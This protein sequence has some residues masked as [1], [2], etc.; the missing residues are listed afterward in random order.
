[1]EETRG[2]DDDLNMFLD[3]AS[4]EEIKECFRRFRAV[5]S[6]DRLRIHRC[7]VCARELGAEEGNMSN[8]LDD[9]SI[10]NLLRPCHIHSAQVLWHGALVLG[11][12]I[13]EIDNAQSAWICND[14]EL[15]L[16][17]GK[18]PRFSLANNLWIGNIPYQLAALTIPE[19]LLI[20]RYYPRCYVFK[21]YPRGG[22]HLSPEV[23]QRGMKGNV[24]LYELNTKDVVRMLEGQ[25]MPNPAA[26][27][28][29]VLAITF[30]GSTA[31]PKDWLKS[32]FRVRRRRVY[33]ALL[34]LKENNSLYGDIC[35]QEDR[36]QSLPEDGVPEE[37]ISLIR[38]EE[39]GDIAD[40]ERESYVNSFEKENKT[41]EGVSNFLIFNRN[42]I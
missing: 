32:T 20:A 30:V 22:C 6:N 12:D 21:L 35:I 7:V 38:Q 13:W 8:A 23:L 37:L 36:L 18:V 11:E 41:K 15:S 33:E 31:L 2:R 39:D 1:V 28:A 16:R 26:S 27:L 9:S 42:F 40:R 14:C 5:T 3:L 4:E 24:S 29:S 19:Q 10:R 34:W 25:V 17:K